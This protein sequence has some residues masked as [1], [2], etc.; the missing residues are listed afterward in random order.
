[1]LAWREIRE[2]VQRRF[3]LARDEEEWCGAVLPGGQTLVVRV[4]PLGSLLMTTGICAE[5]ALDAH[6]A[7]RYNSF[8]PVGALALEGTT[9]LL[10]LLL[11]PE[12]LTA[13]LVE[14]SVVELLQEATRLRTHLAATARTTA[15]VEQGFAYFAD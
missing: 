1:M 8:A 3:R 10:R 14:Q 4:T 6:L 12:G 13:D 7:L 11:A 2:A 15:V 5:A 9:Y